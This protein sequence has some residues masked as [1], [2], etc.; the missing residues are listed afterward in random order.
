M[1]PYCYKDGKIAR[2]DEH[3]LSLHDLGVLRGFG[4]FDFM[5]TYGGKPFLLAE[6]LARFKRS[7]ERI[8]LPLPKEFPELEQ[9]V[10]ELVEK[11]G[12]AETAVKFVLTGGPSDDGVTRGQ[13]ATFYILASEVK[14][15]PKALYETGAALATHEHQRI[16]PE[17]KTLNYITAL[18][19]QRELAEKGVAELLYVSNGRVLECSSSNIFVVKDGALATPDADILIGT[20]RNLVKALASPDYPVEERTVRIEELWD[21][22]EVFLTASNK[23]VMPVT[24]IDGKSIGSGTVGPVTQELMKRYKEATGV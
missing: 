1:N 23:G 6:H 22:D 11:N 13:D 2:L 14:N 4:I 18:Q 9:I 15:P 19:R 24:S 17:I 8:G 10:N 16:L 20:T 21:A 12:F 3:T 5:R 7:A